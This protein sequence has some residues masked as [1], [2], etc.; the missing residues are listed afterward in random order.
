ME[1]VYSTQSPIK[2]VPEDKY[3]ILSCYQRFNLFY[4]AESKISKV[5]S[6]TMSIFTNLLGLLV[7]GQVLLRYVFHS[8]WL[9]VEELSPF[10]ALWAYFLGT[11]YSVRVRDHIGGGIISLICKNI[12]TLKI[13]RLLGSIICFITISIFAYYAYNNMAI[14][15]NLGRLSIYMRWSKWL[16]D[17]SIVVGF[18]I[19][20][21]YFLLQTVLE[22][23]DILC[24]RNAKNV[25]W[26]DKEADK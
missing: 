18:I 14:N 24:L 16:W 10:F 20:T 6:I 15:Y 3:K 11:A 22:L 23:L 1:T 5:L 2:P 21:V 13:I 12:A 26:V 19:S 17:G 4:S 9:G 7:V 8:P 25:I